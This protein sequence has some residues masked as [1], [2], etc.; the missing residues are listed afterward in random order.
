MFLETPWDFHLKM[1]TA[2]EADAG[3]DDEETTTDE[4]AEPVRRRGIG[5][6]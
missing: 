4:P 1:G 6:D 3:E 2:P 5:R